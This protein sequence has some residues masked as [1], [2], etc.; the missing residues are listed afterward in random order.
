[1]SLDSNPGASNGIWGCV[2]AAR[3]LSGRHPFLPYNASYSG[4]SH[5]TSL[6]ASGALSREWERKDLAEPI[7]SMV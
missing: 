6:P 3:H 1:V 2:A 7:S 4:S 5:V